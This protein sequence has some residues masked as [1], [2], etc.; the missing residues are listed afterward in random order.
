MLTTAKTG[1]FTEKC[2]SETCYNEC[3]LRPIAKADTCIYCGADLNAEQ[4]VFGGDKQFTGH[5]C[6]GR[7]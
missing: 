7:L 3:P 6:R 4:E 5:S 1:P 2:S